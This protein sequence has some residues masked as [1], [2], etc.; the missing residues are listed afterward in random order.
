MSSSST[1]FRV[2]LNFQFAVQLF[3]FSS[4]FFYFFFHLPFI[5]VFRWTLV[6]SLACILDAAIEL[7][8]KTTTREGATN[9]NKH[10]CD[11]CEVLYLMS[12]LLLAAKNSHSTVDPK[13]V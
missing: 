6:A 9:A 7:G 3:F 4:P 5:R 1:S 2:A 10:T 13:S 12:V 11:T 8:E